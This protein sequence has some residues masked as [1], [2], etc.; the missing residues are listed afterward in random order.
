[1]KSTFLFYWKRK[2]KEF[3]TFK[4]KKNPIRHIDRSK[5]FI[6]TLASKKY[7]PTQISK[8]KLL[9]VPNIIYNL[10]CI[11]R[12]YHVFSAEKS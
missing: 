4:K 5:E 9:K 7:F 2:H 3:D 1:M 8:L 10:S 6:P 11:E 12:I